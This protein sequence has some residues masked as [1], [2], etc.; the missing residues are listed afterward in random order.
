MRWLF[1]TPSPEAE[2]Q[3]ALKILERHGCTLLEGHFPMVAGRRYAIY[4]ETPLAR[5]GI[6][7]APDQDTEIKL[8]NRLARTFGIKDR[9][10]NLTRIDAA[11]ARLYLIVT[12]PLFNE[13]G[14]MVALDGAPEGERGISAYV[15]E[16]HTGSTYE[17]WLPGDD[18]AIGRLLSFYKEV[19]GTELEWSRSRW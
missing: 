10:I 18:Q 9:P 1:G 3:K 2:F 8:E 12:G 17:V 6:V 7:E 4:Q 16:L 11:F 15:N 14:R 19:Y 13:Q 5:R